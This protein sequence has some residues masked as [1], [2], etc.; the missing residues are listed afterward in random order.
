[1][2]C[3]IPMKGE[4]LPSS[5]DKMSSNIKYGVSFCAIDSKTANLRTVGS[6]THDGNRMTELII[7]RT[8]TTSV[9]LPTSSNSRTTLHFH[10]AR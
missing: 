1:M 5:V 2:K 6:T 9:A 10:V 3:G 8:I 7:D 4:K